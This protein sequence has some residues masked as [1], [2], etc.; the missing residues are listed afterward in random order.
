M[1]F[2]RYCV[3]LLLPLGALAQ[4]PGAPAAPLQTGVS[5]ALA[6]Q[7][8]QALRRVAYTLHFTLPGA[9]TQ[10]VAAT[11]TVRFELRT[12][13]TDSLALDFKAPAGAVQRLAVNGQ[14]VAPVQRREHVLIAPRYL[15]PGPNALEI[16]F[17]A[18]SRSLNR[19]PE[20]AYTLLVPDRARTVFPCF[21]Q[22]DVKATFALTLTV[23][24][25]WQAVANG[26]LVDSTR[27]AADGTKTYRFAPSDTLSTYLFAFATGKFRHLEQRLDGRPMHFYYRETDTAK[28]GRSLG[29]IFAIQAGALKFLQDY[30]QRP[31]PFQKFDF[32][33]IPDFQYGGM[34]HP[35]T[36]DYK[37][38]SLFLDGG[39]TREQLNGRANLLAHET[40]HMWFGDLVTMRWFDDVW[41]KEVFANFM[42]DKISTVTQPDGNYDLKFVTDHY[43]AAYAVDRTA[44]ANPIRQP[45]DNLQAAGSLYGN[46][47]YHKAPIM[48]RQL[49]L[50]MGPDAFRDGLRE[51][52]KRYA[53]GNATWPDLIQILDARTPADLQAWNKVWVNEPGRPVFDYQLRTAGGEIKSFTL[54][55]KGEDGSRRTWPQAFA[56]ALVYADHVEELPADMRGATLRLRAAEGRPAPQYV[57]LNSSGLGYGRFPVDARGLPH[58]GALASPLMRAAAYINLNENLLAGQAGAPAQVLALLR[59]LLAHEPE[60]LNLGLLLDQVSS[61]FWRFTPPAERPALAASLEPELWAAVQQVGPPNLKKLLFKAYAGLA[62]SRAAQDRLH[63]VWQAKRPPAG[64]VL[65]EDDYTDLAAA[66]AVRAYPGYAQI[67]Q[68]Q[69]ARIQNPDRRQ[70]LQY[71]LPSLSDDAAV[72]D[73]FFAGLADAKNR[74]KEA[75]VAS[76][77]A[78]LHHPLRVAYS[79]KYLPQS[80]ALVEELQRTGD[81]FFP[82]TWLGATLRWYR[83]PT[84]AATVRQFLQERPDYPAPLRAKI[85]QSADNLYRAARL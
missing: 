7:R 34:E 41:T 55:Q 22:P 74:E 61:L 23:P 37:A 82:Q 27:D 4:G 58:L 65:T 12:A 63:D 38:A 77:L 80:L 26:P 40:A 53:Y 8:A 31:Y 54:S 42:A 29:P 19:N 70:R 67:L 51:Y 20:F 17:T 66:L 1:T 72:R 44:G 13:P 85:E 28:L 5:A 68:T 30:T 10:P 78:Y 45:L 33:G 36:I 81:I 73:A 47:I 25:A 15:R 32:V 48:M 69:L 60:E 56:V 9:P 3:F 18:G 75:W 39:A 21:D 16:S 76:A 83:T 52:L 43:P 57:L 50:L 35:G 59:P 11:E 62:L 46:I 71:L 64:V 6:A 79:E 84:A 14:A 24:A 2:L 49:E